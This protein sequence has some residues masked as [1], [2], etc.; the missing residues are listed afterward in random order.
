MD[1]K[2]SKRGQVF[3]NKTWLFVKLFLALDF[4]LFLWNGIEKHVK[5]FS[6]V[7]A[8]GDQYTLVFSILITPDK[9][10]RSQ[11]TLWSK[12]PNVID[13]SDDDT[14]CKNRKMLMVFLLNQSRFKKISILN[15]QL[16]PC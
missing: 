11:I 15:R 9:T 8:Q 13:V 4:S 5:C 7:C 1:A 3:S 16:W 14:A 12:L 10:G 2:S 6:G